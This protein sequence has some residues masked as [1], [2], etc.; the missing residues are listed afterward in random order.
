MKICPLF[1]GIISIKIK[2]L[3][4][5]T[6]SISNRWTKVH[7][8]LCLIRFLRQ[9]KI[10]RVNQRNQ[11]VFFC[12][13]SRLTIRRAKENS[14]IQQIFL[15]LIIRRAAKDLHQLSQLSLLTRLISHRI[16]NLHKL[17]TQW[18][19]INREEPWSKWH[20]RK[21]LTNKKYHYKATS[22]RWIC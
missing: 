2:Y 8:K 22:I 21:A 16:I 5:N 12:L 9:I 11:M 14:V 10:E 7:S 1:W 19:L 13:L 18:I 6:S 15:I 4:T 17:K 20:P 3:N